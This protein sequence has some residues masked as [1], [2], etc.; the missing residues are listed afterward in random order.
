MAQTIT[1]KELVVRIAEKSKLSKLD[2]KVVLQHFLDEIRDELAR[3]NR[4]EFR[5]FGV[6]E[7]TTRA[8]RRARN[9]RT[10]ENVEVPAKA[11]VR[12]KAGQALR[13]RVETHAADNGAP[14]SDGAGEAAADF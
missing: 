5:E 10:L 8:A 7:T 2:V 4:L 12:F 3:G 14:V 1:K 6:F 9:P 11:V 13:E